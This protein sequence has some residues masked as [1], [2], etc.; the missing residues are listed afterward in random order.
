MKE[1]LISQD[2]SGL[3][4]LAFLKSKL[5]PQV[6]AR[7]IK[8]DIESGACQ[9]NGQVERFASQVVGRGDRVIFHPKD[10]KPLIS[11]ED[12]EICFLYVDADLLAYNKPVGITSEDPALLA[13][14]QKRYGKAI[15]LHRLDKETTGV[16][17]FARNE[18]MA[19]LMLSLF[20]Q[21]QIH[22]KYFAIVDGIFKKKSGFI[23]NYLGKLKVYQGQTLW[24]E[25]SPEKGLIAKTA[26]SV[27]KQGK[28]AALVVC[29]P[30]TGRTHQ[31]R[32]HLSGMG[33]PILGDHQYGRMFKCPYR[34]DRYL[35]HAAEVEFVHPV[36]G[37]KMC[38]EAPLPADFDVNF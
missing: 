27:E 33:H 25:V 26:W 10:V 21:R 32:V 9:I 20:K 1:W 13:L 34:P 7:Q 17:L 16:L 36:S 3:K 12:A 37:K 31:L 14:V 22:K 38:I 11:I 29:L 24:G 18:V 23:E 2:E 4:L 28:K 30:E 5:D 15:L 19:K 6:S 8:R 35:L